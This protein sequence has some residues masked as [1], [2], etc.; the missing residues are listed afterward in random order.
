MNKYLIYGAVALVAVVL[1]TKT[2]DKPV[3]DNQTKIATIGGSFSTLKSDV[4]K[5]TGDL[6]SAKNAVKKFV[7]DARKELAGIF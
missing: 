6:N 7:S 3:K 1:L 4:K 2:P 5:T